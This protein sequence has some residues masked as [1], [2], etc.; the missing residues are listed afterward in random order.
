MKD[1]V[2]IL[3]YIKL[4][5]S[6]QIENQSLFDNNN[7][8]F[9]P[10]DAKEGTKFP[11]IVAQRTNI[12]SSY[13]KDGCFSDEIYITVLVVSSS[14]D[15]SVDLIEEVRKALEFK[16][17]QFEDGFTIR[18]IR[19]NSFSENIYK[20]AFIQSIDFKITI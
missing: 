19:C 11:Y 4:M 5:L 3:K 17:C 10:I 13:C 6:E 20:D 2:K 8:K 15:E 9:F 18:D 14:Y 7:I 1:S 12:V 16:R